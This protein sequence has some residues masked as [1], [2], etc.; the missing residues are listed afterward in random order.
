MS[1]TDIATNLILEYECLES[2][3][4][5]LEVCTFTTQISPP[6]Q[7]HSFR[8]SSLAIVMSSDCRLRIPIIVVPGLS[9]SIIVINS[10]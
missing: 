4:C 10:S 8:N 2:R 5:S 9:A 6:S 3:T 1:H 7:L